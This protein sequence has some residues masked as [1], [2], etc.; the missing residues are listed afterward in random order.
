MNMCPPPPPIIDLPPPLEQENIVTS[1]NGDLPTVVEPFGVQKN[2]T[3]VA[4]EA[5]N[6][7]MDAP[8]VVKHMH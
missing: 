2:I 5:Q 6:I 8:I 1:P 4:N 3:T 7:N